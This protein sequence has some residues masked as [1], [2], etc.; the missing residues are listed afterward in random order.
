MFTSESPLMYELL[1]DRREQLLR[2]AETERLCAPAMGR[3]RGWMRLRYGVG[4]LLI[5]IGHRVKG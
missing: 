1:Q 3:A 5:T 4:D 2:E